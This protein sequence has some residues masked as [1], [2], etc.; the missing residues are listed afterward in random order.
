MPGR[1]C[2]L[3]LML[4]FHSDPGDCSQLPSRT[5]L[6]PPTPT[7][8]PNK[9]LL[10]P[11]WGSCGRAWPLGVERKRLC[12]VSLPASSFCLVSEEIKPQA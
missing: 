3:L 7:L 1:P 10:L 8:T 5:A 2:E 9:P 11:S 6:V 4:T 12:S